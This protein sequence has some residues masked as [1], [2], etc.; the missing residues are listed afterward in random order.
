MG[1]KKKKHGALKMLAA[2]Q[3]GGEE[4]ELQPSLNV[5]GIA[6]YFLLEC[7]PV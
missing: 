7:V 4:D 5:A 6:D 1:Q 2:L 3:E